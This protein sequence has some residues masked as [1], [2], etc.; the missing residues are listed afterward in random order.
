M[1]KRKL[2]KQAP[3]SRRVVEERHET[4]VHVQSLVAAWTAFDIRMMF[5]G[6]LECGFAPS[7]CGELVDRALNPVAFA[8]GFH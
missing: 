7:L 6:Y 5:W 2:K 1:P 3:A 4:V 8:I